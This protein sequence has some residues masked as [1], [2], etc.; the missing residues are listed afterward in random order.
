M[1][2]RRT[3]DKRETKRRKKTAFSLAAM[4][5]IAL[6]V[7][8]TISGMGAAL[9]PF[10]RSNATDA[11]AELQTGA[12]SESAANYVLALL[13]DPDSRD[14][15]DVKLASP[16]RVIT[17]SAT[18]LGITAPTSNNIKSIKVLV[19]YQSPPVA[20]LP[21]GTSGLYFPIAYDANFDPN[22]SAK[23]QVIGSTNFWRT[24]TVLV[25]Y[26]SGGGKPYWKGTL[27]TLKP[28]VKA[29]GGTGQPP[30]QSIFDSAAFGRNSVTLATSAS[31]N[32][33]DD[34]FSKAPIPDLSGIGHVGGNVG[35]GKNISLS[36]GAKIGGKIQVASTA[37]VQIDVQPT[38]NVNE[39]I[40]YN[41]QD[42]GLPPSVPNLTPGTTVSQRGESALYPL[43]IATG[44]PP[45]SDIPS[46]AAPDGTTNFNLT[47][48]SAPATG[49][50]VIDTSQLS[51]ANLT[52]IPNPIRLFVESS[53][54]SDEALSISQNIG[55]SSAPGNLQIF[56]SG[57]RPLN[58]TGSTVSALIFAPSS[59]VTFGNSAGLTTN[60]N[61]SVKAGDVVVQNQSKISFYRSVANPSFGN[62]SV[63]YNFAN[64]DISKASGANALRWEVQSIKELNRTEFQAAS[65]L[66]P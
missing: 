24:L 37:Q 60:L 63:G 26:G 59:K 27:V 52:N 11:L 8:L 30:D 61:G 21:A 17:L 47:S 15:Y 31:T 19:Q 44:A 39:V 35:A 34:P 9:I 64:L 10:Y 56:Y 41:N 65:L 20:S 33:F 54:S 3:T 43:P 28:F 29:I 50:Y 23:F 38:S 25:E 53:S 66:A 58:F 45:V 48:T 14:T 57:T 4:F 62:G 7:G 49:D 36:D 18:D 13:C 16:L 5:M 32:S 51:Q 12:I 22:S 1:N 6:L 40:Q 42:G 46:L 2:S 55:N